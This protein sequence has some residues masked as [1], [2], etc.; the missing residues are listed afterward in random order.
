MSLARS[1]YGW[2]SSADADKLSATEANGLRGGSRAMDL[3]IGASRGN[4]PFSTQ[5]LAPPP[6][7]VEL[8]QPAPSLPCGS[9]PPQQQS[10]QPRRRGWIPMAY[11]PV[12]RGPWAPDDSLPHIYSAGSST[13]GCLGGGE[14]GEEEAEGWKDVE[15]EGKKDISPPFFNPIHLQ[16]GPIQRFT[17]IMTSFKQVR[18]C[19]GT[20]AISWI[21]KTFFGNV[22][23]IIA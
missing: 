22:I 15:D 8:R 4:G 13:A 5:Q 11:P 9:V 2:R 23:F 6:H 19:N 3:P 12:S 17:Y 16:V 18:N 10:K 20:G 7:V 21:V 14:W 1:T